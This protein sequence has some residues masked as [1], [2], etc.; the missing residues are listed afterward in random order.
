MSK[1][2]AAIAAYQTFTDAFQSIILS[3]VSLE[4]HPDASYAPFVMDG[5]R[6]IYIYVSGLS[7]H[8]QNLQAV[9]Q[10]SILFIADE[11]DTPQIFARK[12][13][14]YTCTAHLIEAET[15]QWLRIVDQFEDRF[16]NMIQL[17]RT[18]PDFRIFQLQPT[19]GR[20]VIGFGAAYA[21]DSND[22]NQLIH[23][24]GEAREGAQTE[25]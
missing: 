8:T 24:Q 1:F 16:G 25:D 6:N 20:F 19:S 3:T 12:R 10:A 17:L 9:P 11:Q 21:V 13:L 18:L 15:E 23:L 4:G 14:S 7:N 2:E 22:L 5:D